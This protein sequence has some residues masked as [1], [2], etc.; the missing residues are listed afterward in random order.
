[1]F[2]AS[3]RNRSAHVGRGVS[4]GGCAIVTFHPTKKIQ[5][6]ER[7]S[8]VKRGDLVKAIRKVS[9][10]PKNGPWTVLCDGE[11]FL[12]SK[13]SKKELAK[14]TVMLWDAPPRCPDLSPV[15]K[16]WAWLR[17][18]LRLRDLADL[19]AK[20]PT[21][22][23]STYKARVRQIMSTKKAQKVAANIAKGS[24]KTCKWV[25]DS[26]GVAHKRG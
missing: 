5:V 18:Q 9:L 22:D 16:F 13:T 11:G 19:R 3:P 15:E 25:A 7:A 12:R 17:K 26:G 2:V 10:T 20:R 6:G 4:E 8:A 23:K 14:A 21:I 24:R 1:M